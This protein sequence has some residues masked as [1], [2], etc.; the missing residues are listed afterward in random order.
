MKP[1][2]NRPTSMR[3]GVHSGPIMSGIVG[4]KNLRF[5][6]FGDTM[7]T[8]ARMVQTGVP[9][10]IQASYVVADLVPSEK[11]QARGNLQ[12]KGK[13]KMKTYVLHPKGI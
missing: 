2:V 13:G 4:T 7:N 3:V 8:A 1:V 9:D 10:A 11:W 6:L 12:I 5:C